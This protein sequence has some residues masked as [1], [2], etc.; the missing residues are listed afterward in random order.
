MWYYGD[1]VIDNERT[2]LF[3]NT[4]KCAKNGYV[5]ILLLFIF[6]AAAVLISIK[7]QQ[8]LPK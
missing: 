4:W 7:K 2:M 6:V 8:L 5:D 1:N 3:P